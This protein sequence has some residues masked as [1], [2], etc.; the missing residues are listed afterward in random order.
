MTR[1][2]VETQANI[3][4]DSA[5]TE[6]LQQTQLSLF[7]QAESF[8]LAEGWLEADFLPIFEETYL[9]LQDQPFPADSNWIYAA[10]EGT[11]VT[12]VPANDLPEA[13]EV[14]IADNGSKSHIG[15][16]SA[17]GVGLAVL[18][19]AAI[20]GSGGG[21][22][23]SDSNATPNTG[24]SGSA[25]D[26]ATLADNPN[27]PATPPTAPASTTNT[28]PA[29]MASTPKPTVT[30]PTAPAATKP[31]PPAAEATPPTVEPTPPTVEPTPPAAEPTP[32]VA[33]PTPPV[34]EPTPP[35]AEPTPPAAEPTPPA[36]E[37]TPPAAEPTPPAAEPTP[38]AAEP[39][40]PAAEPTPPV[41]EPTPPAAEP[42]PPAAEPT[43]PAA[44]PT[45]PV[46]EPTPPTTPA[47]TANIPVAS[48]KEVG[49]TLDIARHFYTAEVIKS[50]ID[51]LSASGGTYL[52]LHLSDDENYTLESTVLNQLTSNAIHN[53]D[54]SY[55]NPL[56]GKQFLSFSQV[57]DI[58]SY[59][60]Q[61][62]IEL[63]PEVD[64]PNHMDAIFTLL[65]AHRGS[66]FVN[67]IK[68]T[69]VADEL[70]ITSD[71]AVAWLKT[72]LTEVSGMFGDSSQHFH[73]GGDEFGYSVAS[74]HEFISY[75]N[76]LSSFLAEK[77]L[78]T[79][80]WND[81]LLKDQL[82][83]LDKS[84]QITYWSYDGN[85]NDAATASERREI[86]AGMD[87]LLDNGF[88]VLNYNWYYLYFVP[89][90]GVTD[91]KSAVHMASD[92]QE[93]WNLGAWDGF[94]TTNQISDTSKIIGSSIAIWGEHA[95]T[96]TD[97]QIHDWSARP[98]A[99]LSSKLN[100]PSWDVASLP[101]VSID[102][103]L[104]TAFNHIESHADGEAQSIKVNP[105]GDV[106][107]SG[108][109]FVWLDGDLGD[110]LSLDK[111]WAPQGVSELKDDLGYT[112]YKNG[113]NHLYVE[114]EINVQFI[115]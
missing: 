56:T 36:A 97:Q 106:L 75:V 80:I 11:T 82:S 24:N 60:K 70:E 103:S 78:T 46:A 25:G 111:G 18:A 110:V 63:V 44:E 5:L 74:N 73:I 19:A 53:S 77:G 79:R 41:A 26:A 15:L 112:L 67:T 62:G 115:A 37:P 34:A 33:E 54:G 104:E 69:V 45:P 90:D 40:P 28:P 7:D 84:V 102:L 76:E 16:I 96:I 91:T 85:P 3:N 51:T 83:G 58:V 95:N 17:A 114:T 64:S 99:A 101:Q 52:Q 100:A 2:I 87:D 50:Y 20:G 88:E 89:D 72:L 55:T 29:S 49:L 9:S 21:S 47:P 113:Q 27:T 48:G 59:A 31:T 65:E 4:I 61:K 30:E 32:P 10:A 13:E 68:S 108:R 6:Q 105:I 92:I 42:T 14:G 39:T 86:R 94:N 66:D 81:G 71:A 43:P 35:A 23:S 93:K 109:T 1:N 107:S 12:D 8:V 98:I 22:D 38:P 57:A